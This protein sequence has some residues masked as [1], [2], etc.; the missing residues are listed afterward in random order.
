MPDIYVIKPICNT[1]RPL[2]RPFPGNRFLT[3]LRARALTTE[4]VSGQ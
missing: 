2:M 1:T 3:S 4:E